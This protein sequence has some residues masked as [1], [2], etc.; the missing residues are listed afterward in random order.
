MARDEGP[1]SFTHFL[2]AA[3]DGA[4]K[5]ELSDLLHE[6]IGAM[7][8]ESSAR[9]VKVKGELTMKLRFEMEPSGIV[10]LAYDVKTKKPPRAMRPGLF[11]STGGGNLSAENPRQPQLPF[12]REVK[13]G[14]DAAPRDVG[15]AQSATK[16]A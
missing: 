3:S 6:L 7:E 16:E 11:W 12:V 13:A 4:L 8:D 5:D 14:A 10:R 1:R 2:E 15:G 9:D